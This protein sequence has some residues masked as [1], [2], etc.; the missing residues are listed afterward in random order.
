M[1]ML[2]LLLLLL[3]WKK[4]ASSQSRR[5]DQRSQELGSTSKL[6]MPISGVEEAM[7]LEG[8]GAQ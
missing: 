7:L 3:V 2:L 1:V 6:K 5:T 8:V 4:I